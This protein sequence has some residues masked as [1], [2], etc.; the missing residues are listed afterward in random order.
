MKSLPPILTALAVA[1][2][3]LAGYVLAYLAMGERREIR[4]LRG[5]L[6]RAYRY[7]WAVA[8]FTPAAVVESNLRGMEVEVTRGDVC[9]G[10]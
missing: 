3:L 8:I 2:L 7:E 5:H 1:L 4:D 9:N 6:Q 10:R